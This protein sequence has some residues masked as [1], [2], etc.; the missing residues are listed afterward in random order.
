MKEIK[1][2]KWNERHHRQNGFYS[3]LTERLDELLQSL[4]ETKE[5]RW[6]RTENINGPY[7]DRAEY[8]CGEITALLLVSGEVISRRKF[9]DTV[10]IR[11]TS[12]NNDRQVNELARQLN[13][14][15][16]TLISEMIPPHPASYYK[17]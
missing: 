13:E 4:G 2:L 12:E 9:P 8:Q 15:A 1:E 3:A 7:E 14:M 6:V 10:Q 17:R 5:D 11:L 16:R